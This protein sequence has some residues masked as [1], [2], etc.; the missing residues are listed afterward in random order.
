MIGPATRDALIEHAASTL[1]W[2]LVCGVD[3]SWPNLD[4]IPLML[5]RTAATFGGER[6]AFAA[7]LSLL[8]ARPDRLLPD[9][10]LDWISRVVT[11]RRTSVEFWD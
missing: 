9:P 8:R 4:A 6:S 2:A 5:G 3:P 1:D 10:D 11:A 7:M